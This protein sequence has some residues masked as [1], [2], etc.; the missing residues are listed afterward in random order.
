MIRFWETENQD[1]ATA[2]V[3]ASQPAPNWAE[4]SHVKQTRRVPGAAAI[5]NC[6]SD[7]ASRDYLFVFP[8]LHLT[9]ENAILA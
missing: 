1:A 8:S 3:C 5:R 2:G 4:N 9:A 6:N 7:E